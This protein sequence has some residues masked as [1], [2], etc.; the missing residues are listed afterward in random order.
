MLVLLIHQTRG[1]DL[2]EVPCVSLT[3]R[4]TWLAHVFK[5]RKRGGAS[6]V[7]ELLTFML[8]FSASYVC[9][10]VASNLKLPLVIISKITY[11][12]MPLLIK[13]SLELDQYL[14]W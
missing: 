12:L 4:K 2:S 6:E 7:H 13:K 5:K 11:I 1:Q 14:N 3:K 9:R 10:I 8:P